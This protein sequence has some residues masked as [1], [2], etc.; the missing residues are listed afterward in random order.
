[1][2]ES[3]YD[4]PDNPGLTPDNALSYTDGNSIIFP[5]DLF[6]FPFDLQGS[7]SSSHSIGL[8]AATQELSG[9]LYNTEILSADD[10]EYLYNLQKSYTNTEGM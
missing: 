7:A 4:A 10:L 9:S 3:Y 5:D 6:N 8:A 2:S 1:M